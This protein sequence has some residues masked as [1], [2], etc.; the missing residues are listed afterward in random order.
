MTPY[1]IASI[2]TLFAGTVVF[3]VLRSIRKP[4]PPPPSTSTTAIGLVVHE[5]TAADINRLLSISSK[6]R[7]RTTDYGDDISYGRLQAFGG[8]LIPT[9]TIIPLAGQPRYLAVTSD[10]QLG[11]E[12]DMTTI[13]PEQYGAAF[14]ANRA[15]LRTTS[16][17]S[18]KIVTAGFSNNAS[19]DWMTRALLAGA[20]D[21]DAICFHVYGDD[22]IAAYLTRLSTVRVAMAR[23]N[24]TKPMW[25]TEVGFT[26][27]DPTK[28]LTQL[29]AF[30]AMP[31]LY[32]GIERVYVYALATDELTDFYG[33][34]AHDA[35]RT[36][37]PAYAAVRAAMAAHP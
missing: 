18:T 13:T 8:N 19:I 34:C 2:A 29:M 21:A 3:F 31:G 30:L 37:R 17:S 26:S 15:A 10:L 20:M 1:I 28:Q 33:V 7:V 25:I 22:L 12:P 6:P 16:P 27:A 36:P 24:C 14:R 11:N 4:A 9:L 35:A 5:A 23:A 32:H